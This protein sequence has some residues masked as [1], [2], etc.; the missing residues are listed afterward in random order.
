MK[1]NPLDD[2]HTYMNPM[3]GIF[4]RIL[5]D[6]GQKIKNA[7]G[8]GHR[9]VLCSYC[10]CIFVVSAT[11]MINNVADLHRYLALFWRPSWSVDR[12]TD[13]ERQSGKWIYSAQQRA[14]FRRLFPDYGKAIER[15]GGATDKDLFVLNPTEFVKLANAQEFKQPL[16]ATALKHILPLVQLKITMAT[17]FDVNGEEIRPGNDVKP[18]KCSVVELAASPL[19]QE[20]VDKIY[21]EWSPQL[22]KG[23]RGG[24]DDGYVPPGW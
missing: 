18:Y 20:M 6:E 11:P 3:R 16:G 15:N 5:L 4:Q 7:T 21:D 14:E 13:N 19:E 9:S 23:A 8:K 22:N 10:P 1:D 17:K 12:H 2:F 24:G